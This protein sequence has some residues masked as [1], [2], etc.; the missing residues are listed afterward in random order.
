VRSNKAM[1]TQTSQPISDTANR[2]AAVIVAEF[3][4]ALQSAGLSINDD[5]RSIDHARD[6]LASDIQLAIDCELNRFLNDPTAS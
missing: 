4:A 3:I 2:L 6:L 1:S 5:T